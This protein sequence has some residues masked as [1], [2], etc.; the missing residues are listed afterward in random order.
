MHWLFATH[1]SV[2]MFILRVVLALVIFAH[3]AQKLLG[4]FGG[5]G[6]SGTMGFFTTSMGLPWLIAFLVIIGESIG[7]LSL[8]AGFL[9][10]FVAASYLLIMLGA[11]TMVHWPN[12]F[13]MN[14]FGQQQGEGFEYHLLVIGMSL[15]L[16]LEGGGAWSL[17]HL[18]ARRIA[19]G[20]EPALSRYIPLHKASSDNSQLRR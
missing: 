7:S 4:W 2:G 12:G 10:R 16:L 9:T 1:T 5:Q 18:I 3:G 14:W 19:Q 15:A 20:N 6:Y 8:L 17:D 11:I 13:F